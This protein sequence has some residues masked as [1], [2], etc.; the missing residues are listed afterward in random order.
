MGKPTFS[1][2]IP[3]LNEE[4]YLPKLLGSLV[5]QTKKNF[6]VIVVDGAST[7]ETVEVVRSFGKKIPKL[8]IIKSKKAN[9]PLQRNLGG[10]KAVGE[11]L[12][13]VDAD[14]ILLPTFFDRVEQFI[15]RE[16]PRLFTSWSRPDSEVA[17]DAL[18]SLLANMLIEGSIIFHRALSPGSLTIVHRDEFRKI[19]GYNES[20]SFAEDYDFGQRLIATGI[21]L[22]VLRETLYVW[23]LRRLRKEGKLKM[24]Q[25]YTTLALR[26]LI[27]KKPPKG[28]RS[29]IMGGHLYEKEKP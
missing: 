22:K 5:D 14:A 10:K 23:S 27:T 16:N 25:F 4:V 6:E 29:Y 12:V 18:L 13:F 15:E 26:T 19:S 20:L 28:V 24:L 3:T 11:W 9:L 21:E 2:I 1:V 17:A 7:D 8:T